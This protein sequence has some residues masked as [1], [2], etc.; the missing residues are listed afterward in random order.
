MELQILGC[1]GSVAVGGSEYIKYGSDTSSYLLM[2]KKEA[3]FLDAGTG[4]IHAP[5]VG[6]RRVSIVLSHLHLDHII[7]LSFFPYIR[8]EIPINIYSAFSVDEMKNAIDR[9]FAPPLWPLKL[10]M[11]PASVNYVQ[12]SDITKIGDLELEYIW[13]NHPNYSSI[14]K[15]KN[16]DKSLV[17]ATD[18]EHTPIVDERL[19]EFSKGADLLMYDGQ[20]SVEEYQRYKS[21][22]HSTKE[23]GVRIFKEA[24]AKKL[25]FIHHDPNHTDDILDEAV[26]NILSMESSL[27]ETVINIAKQKDVISI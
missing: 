6:K 17:Y 4:I 15:L 22:G 24:N 1:R 12:L 18:Y 21:Y 2:T 10:D 16:E 9:V 3:I 19:I 14:I 27:D 11:F 20:Y 7:G 23:D 13:G 25:L 26:N 5:D 8:K